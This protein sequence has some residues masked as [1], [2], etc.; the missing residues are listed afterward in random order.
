LLCCSEVVDFV[1]IA[2]EGGFLSS[3]TVFV[4]HRILCL[5]W[6]KYNK[7]VGNKLNCI[8]FYILKIF[9]KEIEF[10]YFSFASNW[11]IFS[12]FRSFW[13]TDIKKI[14]LMFFYVKNTLKSNRNHIFTKYF[15][16]VFLIYINFN[17]NFYQT[18]I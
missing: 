14:I 1:I 5:L 17:H 15:I 11:Y 12:V 6:D 2:F 13:Y 18:R 8:Y 3:K 4:F 9:L 16:H 7:I 10:F